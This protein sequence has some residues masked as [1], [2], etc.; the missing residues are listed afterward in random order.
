M[1]F[2]LYPNSNAVL[3]PQIYGGSEYWNDY[4]YY[5]EIAKRSTYKNRVKVIS[6]K[7]GCDIQQAIISKAQLMV[8]TRYH[9]VVYAINQG[10]PFV[11]LSYEHKMSGMLDT[12]GKSEFSINIENVLETEEGRQDV[13]RQIAIKAKAAKPDLELRDKAKQIAMD[14]FNAF[15]HRCG[16]G[17]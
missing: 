5:I 2:G 1:L 9:S 8:G 7:Y 15:M 4:P 14:G 6:D 12:L 17:I 13:L 16:L 11:S 3:L 10:I